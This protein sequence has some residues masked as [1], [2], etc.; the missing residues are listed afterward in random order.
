MS[1][2]ESSNTPSSSSG[3]SE[4]S[5]SEA[6]REY[7]ETRDTSART[8]KESSP[9]NPTPSGEETESDPR[10][11]KGQMR[12]ERSHTPTG[13]KDSSS[14]ETESVSK[15]VTKKAPLPPNT[16]NEG[17]SKEQGDSRGQLTKDGKEKRTTKPRG[18]SVGAVPRHGHP[19]DDLYAKASTFPS[20]PKTRENRREAMKLQI[21]LFEGSGRNRK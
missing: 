3:S 11:R 16:S 8:E 20:D 18:T 5:E 15:E 2:N 6:S 9:P 13:D 4:S 21:L 10:A 17:E 12:E 7:Q 1:T 14:S 19:G